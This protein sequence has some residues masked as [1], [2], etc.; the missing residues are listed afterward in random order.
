MNLQVEVEVAV[1][2]NLAAKQ[3]CIA[4]RIV[5]AEALARAGSAEG[6]LD[7]ESV[8]VTV[9]FNGWRESKVERWEKKQTRIPYGDG[10]RS[11]R[12]S[13]E[14][15]SIS[16]CFQDQSGFRNTLRRPDVSEIVSRRNEGI[17]FATSRGAKKNARSH[18]GRRSGAG[19]H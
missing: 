6:L 10:R 9:A 14:P 4:A 11:S 8:D 13:W 16:R 15:I 5:S 7:H 2:V 17:G 3:R 12:C 19:D 18:G 1:G